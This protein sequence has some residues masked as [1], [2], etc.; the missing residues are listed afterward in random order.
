[1][2]TIFKYE[3]RQWLTNWK[4][5]IYLCFFVGGSVLLFAGTAGFF[6]PVNP[7]EKTISYLNSAFQLTKIWEFLFNGILFLVP[8]LVGV[9]LF[10]DFRH[11]IHSVLFSFPISKREYL[12]GKFWAGFSA[13]LTIIFLITLGLI[14]ASLLPGLHP[15]KIG[16]FRFE[17]HIKPMLLFVL[18]NLMILSLITFSFIAY[19]RNLYV[20][21]GIIIILILIS[22]ILPNAI[23]NPVLLSMLDPLGKNAF[24]F[25]T[26]DWTQGDKNLR[27]IP[28]DSLI[29]YN[30]ILWL[31][32]AGIIT[33]L[34]YQKFE[35][36]EKKDIKAKKRPRTKATT[37]HATVTNKR[38]STPVERTNSFAKSLL[39]VWTLSRFNFRY[40]IRNWMFYTIAALGILSVFFAV[41]Q[42]T[43]NQAVAILPVTHVVLS[44]PAFFFT[45]II[46][47]L[48]F[49]YAGILTNRDKVHLVNHLVDSTAVS[50]LSLYLSKFLAL[51]KMQFLLLS[52]MLLVGVGI[53]LQNGHTHLELG[54]YLFHLY[55]IQ[56]LGLLIWS[57]AALFVHALFRNTY[58]GVFFLVGL[59]FSASAFPEI[60]I[61]SRI[62]LFN[63]YEPLPYSDFFQYGLGL[64]G[65]FLG[66]LYWLAISMI[67][68][69]LTLLLVIRGVGISFSKR[70][71]AAK[72]RFSPMLKATG[73]TAIVCTML[74]GF[75]IIKNESPKDILSE[76]ER[77]LAFKNFE[78]AFSKYAVIQVQPKIVDM[79]LNIALYP[80]E[81][82]F[83]IEGAYTIKNKTKNSI[84]TLLIKT[85][86]D[87]TI[88]FDLNVP[89]K[90]ID[91]DEYV[92]FWVIV[93]DKA[94][95][96][97]AA[98]KFSFDMSSSKAPLFEKHQEMVS[99]GS[100]IKN[101]ILP[102]FGYFLSN[103]TD[104]EAIPRTNYYTKDADLIDVHTTISTTEG[105]KAFA[106]GNLVKTWNEN[107][108]AYFEYRTD[109]PIKN[110]LGFLSATYTT[111]K[112]TYKGVDF[113]V[114]A[115]EGHAH[116]ISE[117]VAGLKASFDYNT[118]YFTPYF[119]NDANIIEFPK[120]FG[121]Y[122]SVNANL[123]PTS[124]IR[125][126]A[127]NEN[128]E[129]NISFYIIAHELTHHWWGYQLMPASA[130]GAVM[131]TESVTEYLS[132]NI[133][134][135]AFGEEKARQF[136]ELQRNRYL[137]GRNRDMEKET[138]L[139][140]VEL[141]DQYI[142]YGKGAMA[143]N[144]LRHYIGEDRLNGILARFLKGYSSDKEVYPTSGQ[145]IDTL[146][147]HTPAEYKYLI[148]DNFEDIILHDINID[149]ADTQQEGDAFQTEIQLNA[150]K[151]SFLGESPK[152]LPLDDW[153]EVGLYN[154]KGQ[155]IHVE[156]VKVSKNQQL[157]I[158]T[159]TQKPVQVMIDPNL[160]LL[161]KNIEDNT[162]TL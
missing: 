81:S 161:E 129:V 39:T 25:L 84:D 119:F 63:F 87:E 35:L 32:I 132:L 162:Y 95:A 26:K 42:V 12:F 131:V 40:I 21:L 83:Q 93:L 155:E 117:M 17:A 122:A 14:V 130:P 105:Q 23:D 79:D 128:S 138:P 100:Y 116:R 72:K 153:I 97:N 27:L 61:T 33:Y 20:G 22:N 110:S 50:N 67:F 111:H 37:P 124:E 75:A 18:P 46:S 99:E 102:R 112:D 104:K 4:F 159:T 134:K 47:L 19:S 91:K 2:K 144:T 54:L 16:P 34:V 107:K 109:A 126:I 94:L 48:T 13:L 66:K 147:I 64:K 45:T 30:R 43:H 49:L 78:Q 108:R 96:P 154:E 113:V 137:R 73:L 86:F 28:F 90:M 151:K 31:F 38:P 7:N 82:R 152:A 106:P 92:K 29:L 141:K 142:S 9:T 149:H 10:R 145:L 69:V 24:A 121:S 53:Q 11:N 58:V 57:F 6:D 127:N 160:L 8:A 59:W 143:F 146:R 150:R 74:S 77:N 71:K 120:T 44:I 76:K 115:L 52:I 114:N 89:Y 60:G 62:A 68:V 51:A 3:L 101:E 148:R 1:M 85:G 41:H 123:I 125:F 70:V 36:H 139:K 98:L 80:E 103:S 5:Y 88:T 133:Y 56:W 65:F 140:N 158:V 157:I 55:G 156:K 135:T 118:K 15:N 136:L